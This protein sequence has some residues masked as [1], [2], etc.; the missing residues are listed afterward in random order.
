[1]KLNERLKQLR[2][3][4]NYSQSEIANLLHV[5]RQ[6]VSKWEN[7]LSTPELEK[8]EVLAHLYG[9]SMQ[10]LLEPEIKIKKKRKDWILIILCWI[11]F[12]ICILLGNNMKQ[13]GQITV[14]EPLNPNNP[15]GKIIKK[16]FIYIDEPFDEAK[17]VELIEMLVKREGE[18]ELTSLMAY[19][20]D[21]E[22]VRFK[23][24][25]QMDH[26]FEFSI[27]SAP[28]AEFFSYE[29][30][31]YPPQDMTLIFDIDISEI[32][33]R[34]VDCFISISDFVENEVVYYQSL[35]TSE[36]LGG[37]LDEFK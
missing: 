19:P 17:A 32:K 9:L 24:Q 36:V 35:L 23:A 11:G 15:E 26:Y 29:T 18:D 7:D 22:F 34:E 37:L 3:S 20:I 6:A 14:I 4:H 2:E 13:S 25:I 21:E 31:Y 8:L 16:D 33:N 30:E 12:I 28:N 5:T 1:M 27:E 10:D